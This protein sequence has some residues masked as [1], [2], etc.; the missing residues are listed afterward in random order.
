MPTCLFR[1]TAPL[2]CATLTAACAGSPP[3]SA[4]PPRISLP[5]AATTPCR[6]PVLPDPATLVDLER[7]YAERGAALI[8]CDGARR[9]A[10]DVLA[11]ERALGDP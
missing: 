2:V 8:A 1:R 6:L 7:V 9:L 5:A 4:T 3:T 10:L 11:A